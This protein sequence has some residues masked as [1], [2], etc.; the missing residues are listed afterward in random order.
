MLFTA[1]RPFVYGLCLTFLLSCHARM[2]P[3]QTERFRLSAGPAAADDYPMETIDGTFFTSDGK[4]FPVAPQYLENEWG[5]SHVSWGV[6]NPMQPAPEAFEVTWYSYPEDKFYQGRFA[7]PQRKLYDLLKQGYWDSDDKEHGTYHALTLCVL[8]TG[9]VVVW[10]SGGQNQ[11]LVGRYQAHEIAYDFKRFNEAANRPLMVAQ[12][13]AQMPARVQEEIRTGTLS[14]KQWDTYLKTYPW[15]VE[16]VMQDGKAWRPLA[17]YDYYV[18][19][20]NA[21]KT[22]YAVAQDKASRAAYLE[23]LLEPTPKPVPRYFGLFVQN[24]YGEK[25][26]IRVDSL[27]EHE[28]L[29]AFQALAARHPTEP[30]VLRVEVDKLYTQYRLTLSNGF[31]TVPL[32]KAV[33][34]SFEEE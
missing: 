21:E 23:V 5:V 28:T 2:E 16:A 19:Y 6:G 9:V 1:L 31:Q 26:E 7:L 24:P 29:A 25:H 14:S 8:P 3:Y 22:S 15:R 33:V 30:M 20:L 34:K 27:D 13:R 10:L 18:R 12:E 4:G 11:V 17:L 32:D